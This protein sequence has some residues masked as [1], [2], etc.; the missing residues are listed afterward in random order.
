MRT[1]GWKNYSGDLRT[2]FE[3]QN[4]KDCFQFLIGKIIE[5]EPLN[6]NLIKRD[7]QAAYEKAATIRRAMTKENDR[8]HIKC[9]TM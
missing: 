9:M 5:R 3:I 2:I 6:Q 4:Q 1:G 7:S 8:E